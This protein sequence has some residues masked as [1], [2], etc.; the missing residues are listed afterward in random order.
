MFPLSVAH[1]GPRVRRCKR[2]RNVRPGEPYRRH[3][4]FYAPSGQGLFEFRV[5]D[6]EFTEEGEMPQQ[7]G[8]S[9]RLR[10]EVSVCVSVYMYVLVRMRASPCEY[11]YVCVY[12]W[13]CAWVYVCVE[14]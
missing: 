4:Q 11:V 10:V 9:P 5:F 12:V 7:T 13:M 8:T 3:V 6:G 14:S 2:P 1:T